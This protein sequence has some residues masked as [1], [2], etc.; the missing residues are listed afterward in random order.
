MS[1]EHTSQKISRAQQKSGTAQRSQPTFVSPPEGTQMQNLPPPNSAVPSIADSGKI[2]F[3][4]A[5]R[6]VGKK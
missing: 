3:G 6:L 5:F 1:N 4:A 2:R